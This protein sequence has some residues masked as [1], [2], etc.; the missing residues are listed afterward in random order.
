M[1]TKQNKIGIFKRLFGICLTRPPRDAGCWTCEDDKTVKID[2]ERASELKEPFGAVRLEKKGMSARILV[3]RTENHELRAFKNRCTH[4][5]RRL[6][7]VP[8]TETVQCCS[9]GK[10]TFDYQGKV[11][12][13]SAKKD[14]EVL[15]IREEG[16]H[17]TIEL[18]E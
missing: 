8:E 12:A 1:A 15:E 10:S 9:L 17:A 7:P 13:G 2:L 14:I 6:D 18:G 3:I 4:G 11:L 5:G 16:G